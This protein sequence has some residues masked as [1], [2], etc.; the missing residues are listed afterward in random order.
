MP[1]AFAPWTGQPG[2]KAKD[3]DDSRIVDLID[4]AFVKA[5]TGTEGDLSSV[6]NGLMVDVSQPSTRVKPSTMSELPVF[7]PKTL[8]YSYDR[9]EFLHPEAGLLL[10]GW[11]ME[12]V[13]ADLKDCQELAGTGV[14][15][16]LA[17][18]VASALALNPYAP[19]WPQAHEPS[20]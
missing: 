12:Q 7:T 9:D 17:T 14:S 6:V 3:I 15:L 4:I 19:W 8:L 18:L 20:H 10:R 11:P 5:R 2:N 16:P 1:A 13:S